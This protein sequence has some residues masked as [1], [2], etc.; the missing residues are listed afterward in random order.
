[1][2]TTSRRIAAQY[3]RN[4]PIRTR[5]SIARI[6]IAVPPPEGWPGGLPEQNG[7]RPGARK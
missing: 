1:M 3:K 2:S 7:I 4:K 5:S 6:Y